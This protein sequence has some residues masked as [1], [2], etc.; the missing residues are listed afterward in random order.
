MRKADFCEKV[1]TYQY[2]FYVIAYA[3]LKNEDDAQDAVCS[4]IL[5]GYEHLEQLKNPHKFKPWM[6]A[7]TKNE[8][9]QMKRKRMELPGNEM[10]EELLGGTKE[11]YYDNEL[12]EIVQALKE[13]Y[14]L[15]IVLFYYNDLTMWEIADVLDIPIGTVKSRLSRGKKLLKAVLEERRKHHDGI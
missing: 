4:A 14:R 1:K 12:W 10:V 11:P 8:A 3:I 5:K 13:E 15:V 6:I 2:Q 7:I 9:L